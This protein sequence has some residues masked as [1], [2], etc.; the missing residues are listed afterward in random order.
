MLIVCSHGTRL[1]NGQ[2]C[3]V[4]EELFKWLP[5]SD[6][7]HEQMI[8]G[9]DRH[10]LNK[11]WLA[12]G[13]A[14][15]LLIYTLKAITPHCDSNSPLW[16]YYNSFLFMFD[17]NIIGMVYIYSVVGLWHARIPCWLQEL[18]KY[19]SCQFYEGFYCIQLHFNYVGVAPWL[20][21]L[22]FFSQ[23]FTSY[24]DSI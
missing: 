17:I 19:Y 1:F 6:A 8:S 15:W 3:M 4:G 24:W 2:Q 13:L 5:G 20:L 21:A 7:H 16:F 14:L 23:Q 22:S 11:V 9:E 10:T 18:L 12:R